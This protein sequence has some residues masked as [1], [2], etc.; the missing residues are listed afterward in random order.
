MKAARGLHGPRMDVNLLPLPSPPAPDVT[1]P[2]PQKLGS[3]QEYC[4]VGGHDSPVYNVKTNYKKASHINTGHTDTVKMPF[5]Y[6]EAQGQLNHI[7]SNI[8]I[9]VHEI[10]QCLRAGAVA[11][12]CLF[13]NNG[14]KLV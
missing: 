1:S 14:E 4:W 11:P 7:G 12:A 2:T 8:F 10:V 9:I 5:S 3:G 13:E 6:F